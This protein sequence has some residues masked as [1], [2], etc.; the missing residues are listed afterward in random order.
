[1]SQSS[2]TA[3]GPFTSIDMAEVGNAIRHLHDQVCGSRRRVEITHDDTDDVCVMISKRELEA[4]EHAL[5]V[6][7]GSSDFS[8]LCHKLSDLLKE[9][10]VVF[11]PQAYAGE[12][13]CATFADEMPAR[14]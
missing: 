11:H 14:A 10:G 13:P 2:A 1:M 9:A 12:D 8:A 6:L 4:I 7:T 5:V 3:P